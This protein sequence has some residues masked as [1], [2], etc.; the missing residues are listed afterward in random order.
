MKHLLVLTLASLLATGLMAQDDWELIK[1]EDNIRVYSRK[2]QG[3]DLYV[4]KAVTQAQTNLTAL[5]ALLKDADNYTSWMH[6]AEKSQLLESPSKRRFSYYLHSDVPWPANDRDVVVETRI[7]QRKDK[8]IVTQSHNIEGK[9]PKKEDI[10]RLKHLDASWKF[11]PLGQDQV[12]ITYIGKFK[13]Q[14]YIP[15]WLQQEI[16]LVAPYN[17]I[18]NMRKEVRNPKYQGASLGFITN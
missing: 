5:A 2:E 12:K 9:I 8:V 11:R 10:T 6:A 3:G 1:N 16:Y 7:K 14:D 13:P 18:K 15:D 4:I 17:T